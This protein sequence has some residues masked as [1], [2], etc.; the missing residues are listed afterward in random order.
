MWISHRPKEAM[1]SKVGVV[2]STATG[3]GSKKVTKS[4]SQQLF[5]LGV[6]K[7]FRYNKN[8]N[9]SNWEDVPD[10]IKESI[11][12][13]TSILA[14]KI[15]GNL[16]KVRVGLK[17]KSTFNMMRMMQRTNNW[18]MVDKNYWQKMDI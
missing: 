12:K 5:W 10:K 2:I 1:F 8:V 17:L 4:L 7:V 13:D 18:N 6:P 14:K 3:A 11:E 16:G 15:D 9:A